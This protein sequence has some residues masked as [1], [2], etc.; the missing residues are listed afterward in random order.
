MKNIILLLIMAS[1]ANLMQG[2]TLTENFIHKIPS[3][4]NK[5]CSTTRASVDNFQ[6]SVSELI[7]QIDN[8][9]EALRESES[10]SS[11]VNE[12]AVK[13]KAMQQMSQQYGLSAAQMQQM[14]SGKMSAADKQALANQILQQ[15]TN[16]SM[17]EVQ[18]LKNM[19]EPGRKAYAE[20]L[21]AEMMATQQAGQDQTTTDNNPAN[22]YKLAQEQQNLNS[23]I[24][25]AARKI[26]D[27][28]N[29]VEDPELAQSMDS[30]RAWHNKM[31]SMAGVDYG[32]GPEMK[33]LAEKIKQEK[34]KIC[35][36]YTP[37]YFAA[38]SNHL[39]IMK[40]SFPDQRQLG[41]VTS[42]ITKMQAGVAI[43]SSSVEIGELESVKG[44]LNKLKDAWQ[45]KL[46]FPEDE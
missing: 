13:A 2:Q 42:Q 21:G 8:Q 6:Q 43:P 35:D 26:G 41:D 12:E 9:L 30:I 40:S 19:S 14:K 36:K 46:Y 33:R 32:Q 7:N 37:R 22:L 29:K 3:I 11:Q 39:D 17:G 15:Q 5:S 4:P 27:M 38:L 34:M 20:A 1:F 18:N 45:Y 31:M 24:N 23:K 16:M 25:A 28:Y 44:Y 10:Q